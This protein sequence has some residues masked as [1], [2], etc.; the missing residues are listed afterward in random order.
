MYKRSDAKK[1]LMV[2]QWQAHGR[3]DPLMWGSQESQQLSDAKTSNENFKR[4]YSR[5]CDLRDH[6]TFY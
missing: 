4:E 5:G 3:S 1:Q 2:Q 6:D